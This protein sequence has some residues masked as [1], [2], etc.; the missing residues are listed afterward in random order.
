MVANV[1]TNRGC[2]RVEPEGGERFFIFDDEVAIKVEGKETAGTYAMVTITVAP[3]G[4]PP[5]HAHP[6][7]ETFTV[8]S[9]EFAFTQRD[10][11]GVSTFRASPGTVVHA[12]GGVAHR[13][14]N[15]STT[16]STLL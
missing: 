9:G 10:A 4:G 3:G 7:P 12:Q 15:V 6:G 13:F 8:L 1:T 14:E 11:N 16:P 5:L 2:S